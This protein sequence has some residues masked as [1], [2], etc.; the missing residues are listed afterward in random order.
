MF[1]G[2]IRQDDRLSTTCAIWGLNLICETVVWSLTFRVENAFEKKM[3]NLVCET[4]VWSLADR[5]KNL[6]D[7]K[8][9]RSVRQ[10]YG[11]L[12]VKRL[13]QWCVKFLSSIF[14]PFWLPYRKKFQ[15]GTFDP[16]M[17]KLWRGTLR[18]TG[19]MI[20]S[21]GVTLCR[22]PSQHFGPDRLNSNIFTWREYFVSELCT[23]GV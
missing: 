19:A 4:A 23:S 5:V 2:V 1:T 21:A 16:K 22:V 6:I 9:T 14:S 15:F 11:H 13:Y 17:G 20:R 7:K 12:L 8:M 18:T 10:W 3:K